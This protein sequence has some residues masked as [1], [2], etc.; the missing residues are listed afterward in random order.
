LIEAQSALQGT[1]TSNDHSPSCP[2][3][4]HGSRVGSPES[5]NE[6]TTVPS[7]AFFIEHLRAPN[8]TALTVGAAAATGQQKHEVASG[9][10]RRLV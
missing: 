4:L 10:E 7:N 2:R 8:T 3:V 1:E 9:L 5:S 6:P